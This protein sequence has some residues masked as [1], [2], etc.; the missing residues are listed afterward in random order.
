VQTYLNNLVL[1]TRQALQEGHGKRHLQTLNALS[2]TALMAL[3]KDGTGGFWN[4][5]GGWGNPSPDQIIGA[6]TDFGLQRVRAERD[7]NDN[8]TGFRV[9]SA[10]GQRAGRFFTAKQ[11]QDGMDPE[12]YKV[13]V[14]AIEL[15]ELA[16]QSND[17][18]A[19]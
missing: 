14:A 18:N 1:D 8:I 12:M 5:V 3:A 16:R 7:A 2:S 19:R 6:G 13:V 4:W 11:V 9:Y 17:P 10:S 15:N